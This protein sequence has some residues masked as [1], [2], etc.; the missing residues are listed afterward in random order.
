M[1]FQIGGTS[2]AGPTVGGIV[3]LINDARLAKGL[4]TLGFL[5][6]LIYTIGAIV[7]D[8]FND[9]VGGSNPGCG[10]EGFTVRVTINHS[11]ACRSH[12][13]CRLRSAGIL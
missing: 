10:T 7:P 6:P 9:I 2:A 8:A 12:I 4:P 13:P 1:H 3:S 5:N 11:E